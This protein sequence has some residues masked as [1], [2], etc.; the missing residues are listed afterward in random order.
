M[1]RNTFYRKCD[2]IPALEGIGQ[3]RN[4]SRSR[5]IGR[6]C[7]GIH[8]IGNIILYPP[9]TVQDN[10]RTYKNKLINVRKYVSNKR[11]H[12]CRGN[13]LPI[14]LNEL[15]WFFPVLD[16]GIQMQMKRCAC[17]LVYRVFMH[18]ANFPVQFGKKQAQ[19]SMVVFSQA[20]S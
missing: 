20:F 3:Y 19:K 8:S 1:Y 10:M 13:H 15:K 14:F 4:L 6:S 11:E 9:W 12:R 5:Q 17:F 18:K 2:S 16:G 7:I